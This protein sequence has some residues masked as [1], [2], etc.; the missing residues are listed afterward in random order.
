MKLK[1]KIISTLMMLCILVQLFPLCIPEKAE[2]SGMREIKNVSIS[3]S[4]PPVN[5][6]DVSA[7]SV[8]LATGGCY[9]NSV[10]W[11]DMYG[12]RMTNKFT[13]S[14]ATVEIEIEAS[15][16][17]YFP[18]DVAVSIGGEPVARQRDGDYILKISKTYSPVIWAPTMVKHPGDEEV[19]VG[20]IASFVSYSAC[21]DKSSWQILDTEG[22]VYSVEAFAKK[23]PKLII[24]PSF[25]KLNISPI[26][27]EFDGY[28]VRC[29]FTGPGGDVNSNYALITVVDELP[30]EIEGEADTE[31][32][33]EHEHVFSDELSVDAG[34]HWYE[35]ICGETLD[36]SE[37]EYRWVQISPA[38][39][40]EP[41]FVEGECIVCGTFVYAEPELSEVAAALEMIEDEESESPVPE[42]QS[43]YSGAEN[44]VDV[45]FLKSMSFFERLKALFFPDWYIQNM[46][47]EQE[48]QVEATP[49]TYFEVEQEESPEPEEDTQLQDETEDAPEE[50]P[51]A[52]EY[53][54]DEFDGEEY[55][56]IN[57][58]FSEFFNS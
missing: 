57:E 48:N 41:G 2:A 51:E 30:E 52:V 55:L 16:G 8:S 49:E 26:T 20:G 44:I 47:P 22:T 56:E 31:F 7:L 36:K 15:S 1:N 32:E 38:G 13:G 3:F 24:E 5:A 54:V 11:K 40:E 33:S 34:Y 28:K 53:S 18:G 29:C 6:A 35:C 37:H 46:A 21:T 50:T 45:Q 25:E 10:V 58:E 14:N 12:Q 9:I 19:K 42:T 27:K 39:L 17:Y 23:F 43:D 4:M